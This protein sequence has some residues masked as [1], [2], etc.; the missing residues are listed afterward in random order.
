LDS[1]SSTHIPKIFLFAGFSQP[2]DDVFELTQKK[3]KGKKAIQ[4]F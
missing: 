3:N 1:S 2:N 4:N